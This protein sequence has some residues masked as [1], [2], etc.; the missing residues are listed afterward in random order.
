M[1]EAL[2]TP[3][4]LI[5]T[6]FIPL[7]FLV[8]NVGQAGEIF[9]SGSTPFLEGQNYARLPAAELD[10]AGGVVR[11]A[12]RCSWSRTSR[13]A[14]STSCARRRSRASRSSSGRLVAE[15]V[16]S[17]V[18]TTA[19]VLLALPFGISIASGPLGFVLL[20]VLTAAWA[21]VFSGLHAAHRAQDAQRGG[22]ELGQPDLLPAAVPHAEL[23]AAR[24]AQPADG[25]RGHAQPGDLH[26]GGAALADPRGP[27]LGAHRPR[28]RG[29]RRR[30]AR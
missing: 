17:V 30:S 29:R 24:A 19:I 25:D 14:T 22:D 28:L 3:E 10:P 26:H 4:A 9:P 20:L 5:P 18:I 7:F 13:A 15:A 16:K 6:L 12:R 27:R 2:R 21:V 1:R 8:V 23:R 11:H